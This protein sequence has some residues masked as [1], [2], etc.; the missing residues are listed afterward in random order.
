VKNLLRFLKMQAARTG[1]WIARKKARGGGRAT[2]HSVGR[3]RV[4]GEVRR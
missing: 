3:G 1:D 4:E 2:W